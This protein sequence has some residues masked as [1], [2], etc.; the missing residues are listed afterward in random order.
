MRVRVR[1]RVR[2]RVRARVSITSTHVK[3]RPGSTSIVRAICSMQGEKQQRRPPC[4]G[5]ALGLGLG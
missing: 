2:A 3:P 4:L 1:V 5:F